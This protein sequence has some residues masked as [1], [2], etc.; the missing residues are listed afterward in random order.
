MYLLSV[1]YIQIKY[2]DEIYSRAFLNFRADFEN[3]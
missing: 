3:M 1:Y 2:L